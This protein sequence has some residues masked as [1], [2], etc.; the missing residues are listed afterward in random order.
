[1]AKRKPTALRQWLN[2]REETQT[3]LAD[4]LG[5]SDAFASELLSG[6]R[7]PSLSLAVRIETLTGIAPRDL[8]GVA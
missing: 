7:T 2:S 4:Q 8:A 3:W 5:I 6:K 1:M